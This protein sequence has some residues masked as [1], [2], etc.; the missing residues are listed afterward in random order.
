MYYQ[1]KEQ[2]LISRVWA[3]AGRPYRE[4]FFEKK[5]AADLFLRTLQFSL[6]VFIRVSGTLCEWLRARTGKSVPFATGSF[7]RW[8]CCSDLRTKANWGFTVQV[9]SRNMAAG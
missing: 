9:V 5:K 4:I 7:L 8:Q 6:M 3:T 2:D 1:C